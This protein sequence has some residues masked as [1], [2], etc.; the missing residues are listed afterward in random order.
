MASLTARVQVRRAVA[1]RYQRH[2]GEDADSKG[3]IEDEDDPKMGGI[4]KGPRARGM[5]SISC[6]RQGDVSARDRP[7]PLMCCAEE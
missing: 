6:W 5:T 1:N 7:R 4:G 2:N 3:V